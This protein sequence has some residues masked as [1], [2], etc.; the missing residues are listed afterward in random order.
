LPSSLFNDTNKS[1]IPK[2]VQT[3][4]PL[5]DGNN[6]TFSKVI[7]TERG[8]NTVSPF[9]TEDGT[10]GV[11]YDTEEGIYL[12][13]SRNSSVFKTV[14][15]LIMGGVS[16][17]FLLDTGVIVFINE[18]GYIGVKIGMETPIYSAM[19]LGD[20]STS[21]GDYQ[22][23]LENVK[24]QFNNTRTIL[25][26]SGKVKDQKITGYKTVIGIYKIFFTNE[27]GVLTCMESKDLTNWDFS[28]NF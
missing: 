12:A 3:N 2:S 5:G 24:K 20:K 16:S 13:Y 26:G 25:I 14:P 17:P 11:F 15:F 9:I 21:E 22:T 23:Y 1:P 6:D 7:D 18:E 19:A 10:L 8:T 28:P 4:L 27:D